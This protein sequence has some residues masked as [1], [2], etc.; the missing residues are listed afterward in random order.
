[1]VSSTF[2]LVNAQAWGSLRNYQEFVDSFEKV[3][4]LWSRDTSQH[5]VSV[6]LLTEPYNQISIQMSWNL[7]EVYWL[8]RIASHRLHLVFDLLSTFGVASNVTR[9]FLPSRPKQYIAGYQ[10]DGVTQVS[11]HDGPG[12]VPSGAV[13]DT[14][15]SKSRLQLEA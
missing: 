10:A 14:I 6:R 5:G 12:R 8:P 3:V 11:Q 4:L 13:A 15:G 2:T 9:A 7:V 1:M